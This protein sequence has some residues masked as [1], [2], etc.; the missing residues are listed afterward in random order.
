MEV[1]EPDPANNR[2]STE[3]VPDPVDSDRVFFLLNKLRQLLEEDDFR[4]VRSLE[5]FR[6]SVPVGVAGAT[7]V[8]VGRARV[9]YRLLASSGE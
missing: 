4:A 9:V 5:T 8:E 1:Q 3:Q 7:G 6:E 2:P